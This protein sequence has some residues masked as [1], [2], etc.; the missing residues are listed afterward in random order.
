MNKLSFFPYYFSHASF[1]SEVH[2]II[3][4]NNSI[5]FCIA[6]ILCKRFQYVSSHSILTAHLWSRNHSIFQMTI[7]RLT[8]VI[9]FWWHLE[10]QLFFPF[11]SYAILKRP[12][13]WLGEGIEYSAWSFHSASCNGTEDALFC[14]R[15]RRKFLI[16]AEQGKASASCFMVL[17]EFWWVL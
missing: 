14:V 13:W 5:F 8:W 10:Y 11:L 12:C 16:R 2:K 7:L 15:V 6:I 3:S 17:L 4:V 1:F 9:F